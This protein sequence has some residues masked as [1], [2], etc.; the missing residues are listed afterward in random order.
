[1]TGIPRRAGLLDPAA[2]PGQRPLQRFERDA[3]NELWQ[4]DF[5]GS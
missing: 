2:A 4:M 5:K 3:P 1:V